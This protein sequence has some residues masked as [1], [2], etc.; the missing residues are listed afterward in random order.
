MLFKSINNKCPLTFADRGNKA[1]KRCV[2]EATRK[3][4]EDNGLGDIYNQVLECDKKT[5]KKEKDIFHTN[6]FRIGKKRKARRTPIPVIKNIE[7]I[8]TTEIVQ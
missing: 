7:Y 1:S 4:Y 3:F 5:C 8:I 2:N 6:L